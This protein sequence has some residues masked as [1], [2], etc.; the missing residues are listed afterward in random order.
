MSLEMTAKFLQLG[1]RASGEGKNGTWTKQEL[2][3][4]TMDQ[5]PRKICFVCWGDLADK[6]REFKVGDLLK[7]QFSIESRE[8]NGR[9]YT[10]VKPY[11]L[12]RVGDGPS[13]SPNAPTS[14]Y[15]AST[16][17]ADVDPAGDDLPF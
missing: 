13:P 16:S 10:D 2:I 6:V 9:W 11:R 5:Y 3:V 17:N 1:Q 7:L 15:Q 14:S 12:D 8:F 4:E